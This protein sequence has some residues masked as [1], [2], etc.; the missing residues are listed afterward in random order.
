[1]Q[2]VSRSNDDFQE[3]DAPAVRSVRIL[4]PQDSRTRICGISLTVVILERVP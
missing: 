3:I 2:S 4:K 1:M